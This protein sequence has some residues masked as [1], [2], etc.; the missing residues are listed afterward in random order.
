MQA[1]PN[2]QCVVAKRKSYRHITGGRCCGRQLWLGVCW[3]KN[4]VFRHGLERNDFHITRQKQFVGGQRNALWCDTDFIRNRRPNNDFLGKNFHGRFRFGLYQILT[5]NARLKYRIYPDACPFMIPQPQ[6]ATRPMEKHQTLS[7]NT[8]AKPEFRIL[9][10]MH[11]LI[12]EIQI[13]VILQ[14]VR[15]VR[16]FIFRRTVRL[17]SMTTTPPE[18]FRPA[19]I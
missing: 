10:K 16:I 5:Q 8:Y 15:Q 19:C 17:R 1:E 3:R 6:S 13:G 2:R 9:P 4:F 7:A 14:G 18:L 12:Q 11:F